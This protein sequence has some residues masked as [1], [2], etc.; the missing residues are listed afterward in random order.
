MENYKEKIKHQCA[1]IAVC[2]FIIAAISFLAAAAEFWDLP[3]PVP[4]GDSHWQA[5]WRGF[6]SGAAL[7][8][9]GVMIFF[10]VRNI[11]A[12]Q[13]DASLKKLYVKAHD[14]RTVKVWQTA[15]A[16]AYRTCLIV[17][18]VAAIVSGYFSMTVSI[19]LI[20][21]LAVLSYTGLAYKFYYDKKF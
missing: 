8:V 3:F 17:S 16:E 4:N 2:S 15:R 5:M 21:C 10:L 9:L 1:L 12:L 18:I 6:I 11:I 7:G 20:V 19:T 14:E 13:N